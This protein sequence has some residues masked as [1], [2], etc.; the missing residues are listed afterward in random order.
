M[1]NMD[2]MKTETLSLEEIAAALRL[3]VETPRRWV[4]SGKLKALKAGGQYRVLRP[5]LEEFL[6]M[7]KDVG[8][9]PPKKQKVSGTS[10]RQR[11]KT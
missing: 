11:P 9:R 7:P 1:M 8:G 5:A 4:R 2:V 10:Q 3:N 6:Q